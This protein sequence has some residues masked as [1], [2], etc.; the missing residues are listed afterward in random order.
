[1]VNGSQLYDVQ[2]TANKGWNLTANGA[3]SSNVAPGSTVDLNNTDGNLAITKTG[4]AVTFNL[5]KDVTVDS[6]T[7]G[8]SK[9]DTSGLTI[10]GGPSVTTAGIDAGNKAITNVAAGTNAADAVNL[11]QL[12]SVS[13]SV[14]N[15]GNTVNN[16]GNSTASTIGGGTTYDPNTGTLSGFSQ[17]VTAVDDKGNAG[18]ASK[19]DT[20]GG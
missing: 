6:V 19:Y 17:T 18:I 20:V 14:T 1:A 10:A 15:L 3:N 11:S 4:N 8:N 5:S 2:Q 12:N 9:L 13:T 16:L 7:A